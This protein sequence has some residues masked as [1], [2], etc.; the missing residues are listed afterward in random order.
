M[1]YMVDYG[2]NTTEIT[3]RANE[4]DEYTIREKLKTILNLPDEE[5]M[6]ILQFDNSK[7]QYVA[8][9]ITTLQDFAWL[10]VKAR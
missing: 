6:Q 4:K 5:A 7:G 8:L 2:K 3:L 9:D 10:K 1:K